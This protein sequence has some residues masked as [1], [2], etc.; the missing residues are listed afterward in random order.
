LR[1]MLPLPM[2]PT[3]SIAFSPRGGGLQPA[4]A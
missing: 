2:I 4:A 1:V 3:L